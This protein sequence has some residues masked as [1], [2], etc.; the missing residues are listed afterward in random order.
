[1]F[2]DARTVPADTVI[3]TD[4]CIV[5]A[6]A[7]G[8]TMALEFAASGTRVALVEGGGMTLSEPSQ[9]LYAGTDVGRPYLDLMTCR[10]RF[11]GGT[12]NHWAG[13]CL[14]LDPIDFERREG[15]PYRGWPITR[16]D[17]DPWYRR[18]Q[19][20]VQLGPFDYAPAAWGVAPASIPAPFDRPRFVTRI[21]QTSPPTRFGTT[22]RARLRVAPRLAVYL[23]ANALGFATDPT[24][25]RV[26]SLPVGTLPDG[27]RFSIRA[28]AFVAAV[29][30]VENARLLLLSGPPGG[31]GVGNDH[32]LL[33]R[34]FMTH[35]EYIS[36]TI[37]VS[38]PYADF[39]FNFDFNASTGGKRP[40]VSFVAPSQDTMRAQRLANMRFTWS[41]SYG[42]V[43]ETVAAAKRLVHEGI[44][45]PTGTRRHP[46]RRPQSRRAGRRGRPRGHGR[47]GHAGPRA[48]LALLFRAAS[49]S[50]QPGAPGLRARCARAAPGGDGL[51]ADRRRQA[52]RHRPARPARP[53]DRPRRV[54]SLALG[55]VRWRHD[56]AGGH[57]GRCASDGDDPH[58]RRSEARGGGRR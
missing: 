34:F 49:Q 1:M 13:W 54:R 50:G 35:M 55:A 45:D 8:I 4:L 26:H 25:R 10:L 23:H 6:G 12:T 17:L 36:G 33:G 44:D 32:D 56:L 11:F 16:A 31:N 29:G 47:A 41:Y 46:G 37:A 24:G 40:F 43:R 5:G 57:G 48:H 30:G 20:V 38:K 9:E 39:D 2:I 28:R 58:A 52:Q 22:Y 53:R 19:P 3:E 18:A 14:P 21:L 7:A 51:A 15:L 42:P 27:K